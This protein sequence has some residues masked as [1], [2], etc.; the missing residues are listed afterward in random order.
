MTLGGVGA[1]SARRKAIGSS[2]TAFAYTREEQIGAS[3][4]VN[5]QKSSSFSVNPAEYIHSLF[6]LVNLPEYLYFL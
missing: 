4:E 6:F 2:F 5:C 3:V 1:G